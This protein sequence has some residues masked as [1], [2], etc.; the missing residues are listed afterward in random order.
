MRS[1]PTPIEVASVAPAVPSSPLSW[2]S[3]GAGHRVLG[4]SALLALL[5]LLV[6][7]AVI[8]P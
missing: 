4:V 8:L 2:L 7:W 6:A 5:W 1:S 3:A